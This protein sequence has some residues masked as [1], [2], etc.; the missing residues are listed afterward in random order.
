MSSRRFLGLELSGAKNAKTALATLELYEKES[1]IFLLDCFERVTA[2]EKQTSDGA[3]LELIEEHRDGLAGIGVNVPLTLPPCIPCERKVCPTPARCTVP[4]VKWMREQTKRAT[5]SPEVSHNGIR[6]LEFTPYTQRPVEL[7]IRYNVLPQLAP[8]LRFEIDET[9][10]GN[11]APLSAR[12]HYLKRHLHGIPLIEVWPK[13]TLGMLG[14]SH[15]L[16]A[17]LLQDYRSV[18]GGAAARL[19][20]IEHLTESMALF[21]YERDQHKLAENL[22]A[23]DA[24]L[25]ALTACLASSGRTTKRPSRFFPDRFSWVE[26]PQVT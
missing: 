25:C 7:W 13:L 26:Y 17:K 21:I 22:T 19:E 12:M 11:R 2:R 24:F 14:L 18:D 23:F 8:D 6:V 5:R 16:P 15:G 3:L 1:K 9:L 4:E 20:I 10:G